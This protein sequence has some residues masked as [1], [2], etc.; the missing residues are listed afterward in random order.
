MKTI[1]IFFKILFFILISLSNLYSNIPKELDKTIDNTKELLSDSLYHYNRPAIQLTSKKLLKNSNIKAIII[2]DEIDNELIISAYTNN[3][4][5]I[6]GPIPLKYKKYNHIKKILKYNNKVLGEMLVYYEKNSNKILNLNKKE[7][8][9]IKNHPKIILGIGRWEPYAITNENGIVTGY[10][11]E[12]LSLINKLSG[13]NFKLKTGDWGEMQEEA[14]THKIDGL[15]NSVVTEERKKYFNPSNSY[16]TV[17]KVIF[18]TKENPSNI[19]TKKDLKGKKIGIHKSNA[20]ERMISKRFKNSIIVEFNSIDSVINALITNKIDAALGDNILLYRAIK[21]DLPYLKVSVTLDNANTPLVFNIRKDWSEAISIINKSLKHIG[22][23]KLLILKNKWFLENINNKEEDIIFTKEEILYLKNKKTIKMCVDPDWMPLEKIEKGKYTGI[24]SDYV[25]YFEK[26]FNIPIILVQTSS[27]SE[28]LEYVRKRKCDILPLAIDTKQRR[29]YLSFTQEYIDMP[30]AISTKTDKSF[31]YDFS[32][33]SRDKKIGMVSQYAYKEL[34]KNKY[35]N[36]NIIEVKNLRDGLEKVESGEFYGMIDIV[37]SLAYNIQKNYHTIL[38]ITGTFDDN[39]GLSVGIRNDDLM[40][41][42]IYNKAIDN[43]DKELHQEILN[44]WISVKYEKEMNYT[45]IY[46][47]IFVILIFMFFGIYRQYLLNK[48]NKNLQKLVDIELQKNKEKDRMM[49]IQS[50]HAAMGEMLALITH[51]WRQPLNEL[52]LV[53]QKFKYAHQKD[54]L[55][56]ELIIEQTKLGNDLILKMSTTIDD[57]KNFLIP[58]KE[59]NSFSLSLSIKNIVELLNSSYKYNNINI[60]QKIDEIK[61]IP[62]SKGEFEQ[63]VLNILNNARDTLIL[64][65]INQKIVF[66]KVYKLDNHIIVS[67][68]DNAGGIKKRDI[69]KVFDPYFTTKENGSGIGLYIAKEIIQEHFKGSI[70]VENTSFE[71]ENNKYL[72]ACFKI[73][74]PLF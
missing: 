24:S 31:I 44:K 19:Y 71:L 55:T 16:V 2:F 74:I 36:L 3:S 51:Q 41:L 15:S 66:I 10:D 60:I 5:F 42:N 6:E 26:L 57:F 20:L 8:E 73:K 48:S 40:L 69:N 28:S 63:V 54:K 45:I 56:D 72:G 7:K 49:S 46:R 17:Q 62:G 13:A 38:K 23:D 34:L 37:T 53:L 22:K 58:N 68:C 25:K 52:G 11:A 12:V 14:K 59:D 30:L 65:K 61:E 18:T 47:I 32:T 4:Q 70:S 35:K 67:I 33:I 29:K 9:F 50:K 43:I 39:Y 1:N 21:L 64:N 27:W